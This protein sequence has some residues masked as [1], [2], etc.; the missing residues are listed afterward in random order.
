MPATK[1]VTLLALLQMLGNAGATEGTGCYNTTIHACDPTPAKCS[2][3][4]CVATGGMWVTASAET[5]CS[6]STS[7]N[8]TI[9]TAGLPAGVEAGL[10]TVA[11]AGAFSAASGM[12]ARTTA[13]QATDV[14]ATSFQAKVQGLGATACGSAS[15]GTD[16]DTYITQVL[17]GTTV[18]GDTSGWSGDDSGRDEAAKKAI[19][20]QALSYMVLGFAKDAVTAGDVTGWNTAWAL[21]GWLGAA[22]A[23]STPYATANKRCKNYGTCSTDYT[24]GSSGEAEANVAINAAF[25]TMSSTNYDI[26]EANIIVT[27]VQATLRYANKIDKDVTACPATAHFE[28]QG[29]GHSFGMRLLQNIPGLTIPSDLTT[30]LTSVYMETPCDNTTVSPCEGAGGAYCSILPGVTALVP[31]GATLGSMVASENPRTCPDPQAVYTSCY[32]VAAAAAAAAADASGAGTLKSAS[33]I[34]TVCMTIVAGVMLTIF[35]F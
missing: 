7:C 30:A 29:E 32:D 31:T 33:P 11:Q 14:D 26:I 25:G 34:T 23:A 24:A 4:A 19:Y 1:V 8:V 27:Y 5:P 18:T 17:S 20:N 15:C 9:G 28:H 35:G 2:P 21:Y 3:A 16:L 6:P 12:T 10:K 22:N 13:Y